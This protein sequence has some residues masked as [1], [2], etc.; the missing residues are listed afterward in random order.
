MSVT[1]GAMGNLCWVSTDVVIDVGTPGAVRM[2]HE[3]VNA[4]LAAGLIAEVDA[5]IAGRVSGLL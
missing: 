4:R 5:E 2:N 3:G 1:E